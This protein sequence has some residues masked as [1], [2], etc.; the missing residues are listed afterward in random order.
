LLYGRYRHELV[1]QAGHWRIAK[2]KIV[3]LNDTLP[4]ILDY[5]NL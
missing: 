2:K 1:L 3:L 5:Y 4:A